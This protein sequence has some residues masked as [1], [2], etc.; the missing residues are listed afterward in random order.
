MRDKDTG[1]DERPQLL[2]PY[3][4]F[5]T[6]LGFLEKLKETTVPS[7]IDAAV[8]KTYSGTLQRMIIITL[9][10]LNLIDKEQ[11]VTDEMR[12]LVKAYGTD[13]WQ[14]RF[15]EI[16]NNRY[17]YVIGTLNIA[18]D[19]T[20]YQLEENFRIVG[21]DRGV[22][23]KCISFY[24][25][26]A[27]EAGIPLSPHITVER[28][29]RRPEQSRKRV[30][31]FDP[32]RSQNGLGTGDV[33]VAGTVQFNIPVLPGKPPVKIYVPENITMNEWKTV[34]NTMTGY[35]SLI[36]GKKEEK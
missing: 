27:R 5:K 11:V 34:D 21:A 35:I 36:E 13:Q 17:K 32:A 29:G 15:K 25:S 8:L 24:I 18:T 28:R 22:L 1:K 9:K 2:P 12:E 23:A 20:R 10:S 33:F 4:P 26:A 31:K 3:M 6:F 14:E 30:P 19:A 16:I 7:R